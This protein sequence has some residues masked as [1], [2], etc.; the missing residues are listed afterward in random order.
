GRLTVASA[1]IEETPGEHDRRILDYYVHTSQVEG[2]IDLVR[3]I[4]ARDEELAREPVFDESTG[5]GAEASWEARE[6]VQEIAGL[7]GGEGLGDRARGGRR[8]GEVSRAVALA[9]HHHRGAGAKENPD[10]DVPS[11]GERDAL[12]NDEPLGALG[13]A[14]RVE[15]AL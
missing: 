11:T 12:K 4:A 9:V 15:S 3:G 8:L 2:Q 10:V 5:D 1:Q 13:V 14:E 6:Q 7:A